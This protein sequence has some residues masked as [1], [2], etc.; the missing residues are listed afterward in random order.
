MWRRWM[1][2][3]WNERL[4]EYC[5]R[6]IDASEA[7][8]VERI[9]ATPEELVEIVGDRDADPDEV[10]EA[11]VAAVK[12][13]LSVREVNFGKFC[14]NYVG[15]TPRSEAPPRFFAALW[16]TCLVAYGYP[17]GRST[18]FHA[19]IK[20]IFGSGASQQ[21]NC[22]PQAW[23]DLERWTE[24]RVEADAPMRELRLPPEDTYRTNIGF[25]WFLAFPHHNDRR[26]LYELLR[27]N[28]LLGDEPPIEPILDL[29]RLNEEAFSGAFRKDFEVFSADF[30]ST[31]AEVRNSPFWRAV[32]QEALAPFAEGGSSV[33]PDLNMALM[34]EIDDD[35]LYVY[36]AC[37]DEARLPTGYAMRGFGYELDGFSSQVVVNDDS[38]SDTDKIDLA[39]LAAL[40][41]RLRVPKARLYARRGVL[42][43]Q[44]VLTN[45]FRLAGGSGA[46]LAEVALVRDDLVE[47]FTRAYGGRARRSHLAGW[48]QVTHCRV[49]VRPDAPKGLERV[50]HL[51]ETMIPPS[52]RLVEGIRTGDGFYAFPGFLPKVRF[53]GATAI[54]ILDAQRGLVCRALRSAREPSE[55]KLPEI[56]RNL[57]PCRLLVRA[58]W[59]DGADR[60]RV[61]E[62]NLVFVDRTADHDYKHLSAGFYFVEAC[63]PGEKVIAGGKEVPLDIATAEEPRSGTPHAE[64]SENEPGDRASGVVGVEPDYRVAHIADA[65]AALSVRKSWVPR[66]L[67]FALFSSTLGFEV[68]ENPVLF[69]DLARGWMEAGAIDVALA[70]N[71][72]A[73]VVSVRRPGFVAFRSGDRVRASLIGV[74][75]AALEERVRLVVEERGA[76]CR[77]LLPPCEWQPK[78]LWI[79]C[80]EPSTVRAISN[81]A[82]L[83]PMRWLRWPDT[84][85]DGG[86]LDVRPDMQKLREEPVSATFEPVKQWNWARGR[87]VAEKFG[88]R[89]IR[90]QRRSSP[91]HASVYVV[92]VDGEDWYWTYIRNWALLLSEYLNATMYEEEA[93]VFTAIESGPLFRHDEA[94]IYLPL[95]VGRLCAVLGSGLS[96]PT[97]SEDGRTV[98]GYVYP[99]G[100]GYRE[101]LRDWLSGIGCVDLGGTRVG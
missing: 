27:S 53:D 21:M 10:V 15:W 89:G 82:D 101:A 48:H 32:R 20:E 95:P 73:S 97:L 1:Y 26:K 84:T 96:G 76:A 92:V 49:L 11:F 98:D 25:S 29:L 8:S 90:V 59:R 46:N 100:L 66:N 40:E 36:V 85:E 78:V 43:F 42:V 44:E 51:Q 28:D 3:Q 62:T 17:R 77:F 41:G 60:P 87:F 18:G 16:L 88:K 55:W 45:E 57:A 75:P 94:Y 93:P 91:E 35:D 83:S 47:H 23:R 19:R 30:L 74:V 50:K 9:P 67:L 2:Q 33:R 24:N 14:R 65:L 7:G 70:Q 22:L 52:V 72:K 81:R 58:H 71:K 54:E 6:K 79:E 56:L 68:R 61:S 39:A 86:S 80:D 13:K 4:V 12:R 5:F 38:L 37:S 64:S 69:Y 34:A 63:N 99:L 31:G